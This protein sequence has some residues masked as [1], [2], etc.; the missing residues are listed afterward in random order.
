MILFRSILFNIAFYA[1]TVATVFILLPT[2]V[3]TSRQS[4]AGQRMWIAG[5]LWLLKSIADIHLE[6][7]GRELIPAGPAIFA[8]KHHSAWD[9]FIYHDVLGDAAMVMKRE[10]FWIP[11]YGWYAVKWRMI[12][13]DRSR[14]MHALR[15]LVRGGKA[16]L[17]EGR[18]IV[19]FPEGTRRA[20]GAPP[21]YQPG[22]AAMYRELKVAV[23]PVAVNSGLF[24]PRRSF[25]KRPGTIV[26]EILP[27]IA[28]GL[29]REV[30]M[31]KLEQTIEAATARLVD[32]GSP[33]VGGKIRDNFLIRCESSLD[34]NI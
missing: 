29:K 6:V 8:A 14:G 22:V 31:T 32:E 33:E 12:G 15:S 28:P 24:W 21:A 34:K 16:A 4:R 17:A 1:W 18:S 20:V 27:A 30:F 3:L 11:L 25:R 7:R 2:M 23:V 19:I 10:L 26:L 5:I 13:V 9:T